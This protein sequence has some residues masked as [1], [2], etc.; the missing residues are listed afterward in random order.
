MPVVLRKG[1]SLRG[2]DLFPILQSFKEAGDEMPQ[3]LAR[4]TSSRCTADLDVEG[5][6]VLIIFCFVR[7]FCVPFLTLSFVNFYSL[8]GCGLFFRS[9]SR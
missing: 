4:V 6:M 8:P 3:E 9:G 2:K 5:M 1:Y 7:I